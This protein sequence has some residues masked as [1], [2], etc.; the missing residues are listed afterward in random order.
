[1]A[2][3]GNPHD[4]PIVREPATVDTTPRSSADASA[5]AAALQASLEQIAA[6]LRSVADGVMVQDPSGRIL[7]A[8][9]IAAHLCGFDSV[10]RFLSTPLRDVLASF[11]LLD[12]NGAPLSAEALPARRVLQGAPEAEGLVGFQARA[13]GPVHW[14]ISRSRPVLDER[15]GIRFVVS[16]FQEVTLLKQHEARERF[17]SEVGR[18]LASSLDLATTLRNVAR[19]AVPLYADWCA[20]HLLDDTGIPRPAAVSHI[21]PAREAIGRDL[22]ERFPPPRFSPAG[23]QHALRTGHTDFIPDISRVVAQAET[24]QPEHR[25][26]LE[27]LEL[28]ASICAPL[29]ARG[30]TLGTITFTMADSGR[31]YGQDDVALVEEV[32]RRAAVAIDNARLYDQSQHSLAA[33]EEALAVR[34]RFLSMASHE[35]RTPLAA[36]SGYID[37]VRRRVERDFPAEAL[38]PLLDQ[39]RRQ[40]GSLAALIEDLLDVSGASADRFTLTRRPVSLRPLLQQIVETTRTADPAR[41]IAL[42]LPD[43]LPD[44]EGDAARLRQLLTNLIENARSFSADT[45]PIEVALTVEPDSIAVSVQDEGIGIPPE[46]RPRIFEPFH[47]ARNVD[48]HKLAGLGLGLYIAQQ[49][50][51]AHEGTLSVSSEPGRGSTFTLALPLPAA[52]HGGNTA[53]TS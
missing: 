31:D 53:G 49:I 47:R 36:L 30:Q 19:L 48:G 52:V 15:G 18:V 7:Y 27:G 20:V 9:D 51:V 4:S 37:L 14:S 35:L 8:N 13:R 50:A 17:L 28:H 44:I 42:T 41:P 21:D 23:Y 43:S 22:E 38:L 45:A 16:T 25:R 3:V 2:S 39:A 26:L 40:A 29:M 33:A 46:D 5:T 32:A 12:E 24:I 1:M 6:I 34:E 11:S 10:E